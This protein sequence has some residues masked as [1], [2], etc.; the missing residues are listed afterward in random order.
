MGIPQVQKFG[1]KWEYFKIR[2]TARKILA[3]VQFWVILSKLLDSGRFQ[4]VFFL[5]FYFY[6]RDFH[7]LIDW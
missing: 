5:L 6:V 1:R 2:P 7:P 4:G 3:D